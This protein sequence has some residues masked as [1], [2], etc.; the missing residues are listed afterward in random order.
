MPIV[1]LTA[2]AMASQLERCMEAG[3]NG[4]LTKP[5]EI[6][7]LHEVLT[8]FGLLVSEDTPE[9]PRACSKQTCRWTWRD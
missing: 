8:K 5:L 6:P 3:M 7:R 4:F 1:A 2:N 9:R